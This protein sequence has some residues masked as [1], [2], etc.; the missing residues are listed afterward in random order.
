[1]RSMRE[2]V[3]LPLRW[4]AKRRSQGYIAS[5]AVLVICVGAAAGLFFNRQFVVDQLSVWQ[6]QPT[7]EVAQL[8]QRSAM[9][10]QGK[11]YFYSSQPAVESAEKFNQ[12]CTKRE[13]STA[14]LGC[15]NGRNI[16]IYNVTDARL[17]GIKEVTAA[18]E[19]LH[20][21]YDRLSTEEKT[22]VNTL[23]EA[24]YENI[25]NNKEFTER[26]AF[27]ARTEP[28]ERANELH[29]IIGTEVSSISPALEEYY[30]KYFVDRTKVVAL[31]EKYASIFL[32]LQKRSDEIS[33]QLTEVGNAIEAQSAS[34]NTATSQLNADIAA[35]NARANSGGFDSQAQFQAERNALVGRA[36]QLDANRSTINQ[37][38]AQYNQLRQEL[39]VVA[40]Q[41]KALNRSIN[42]SLE[43][44]PSL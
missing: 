28:G 30:K 24:E 12:E 16:F 40:S 43:P 14:I 6:Y 32:S 11:F 25:K 27:Y 34:Y 44:A 18:H 35:F 41:S 15:Y 23:L 37:L 29:S 2:E 8:A 7:E 19:M 3:K 10:S 13:E 21:A 9:N 31:H 20:A 38:I 42:S 1:M 36:R 5:L 4:L 26:M 17:D 39:E 33:V 22:K